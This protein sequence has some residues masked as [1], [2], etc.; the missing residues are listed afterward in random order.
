MQ[1]QQKALGDYYAS[2]TKNT[3]KKA[4]NHLYTVKERVGYDSYV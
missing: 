1:R 2:V 3:K 4:A